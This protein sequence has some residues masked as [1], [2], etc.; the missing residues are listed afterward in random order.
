M[1]ERERTKAEMKAN[2]E[3]VKTIAPAAFSYRCGHR[4]YEVSDV[5]A[6]GE[7]EAAAW[8]EAARKL[9]RFSDKQP[10]PDEGYWCLACG[11]FIAANDQGVIVHDDVPHPVYMKFDE[12]RNPQ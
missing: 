10:G 9:G 1:N 8:Y 7:T 11:R 4:R 12:E 3:F 2:I 5:I 6:E